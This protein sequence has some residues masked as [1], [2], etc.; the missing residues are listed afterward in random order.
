MALDAAARPRRRAPQAQVRQPQR[1]RQLPAGRARAAAA[2]TASRSATRCRAARWSA[3]TRLTRAHPNHLL[4][5]NGM[6]GAGKTMAAIILLV[7]ALAQGASGF[8]IDRAGHFAFLASLIP[9]ASVGCRSAARRTRST[10]WDVEDPGA[11]SRRRRST[12]CSRCTRCCSAS[13]TPAATATAS[14][15]WRR[16]CSGLAI[17][18]VYERCALTGE[19]PRE[20]LLQEEL[21]RRYHARARR[22]VGRDRGGAAEPLDAPE[23]LLSRRPLRLS[24]R[25]ADDDPPGRAA[26]RLRHAS[27][28]RREGRRGA[29]RDLRARQAHGSRRPAASTSPAGPRARV[30]G[31]H[32]SW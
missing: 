9:G 24:H 10:R 22:G 12:I 16:T 23:Q 30:G 4:L 17:G 32:A 7:R 6:S 27:D 29:V 11:V 5:I 8:I 3:W 28:P 20:L 14:P 1:R 2:P 21:E 19:E 13:T 31:P 18:E 25:P 15:T 26:G